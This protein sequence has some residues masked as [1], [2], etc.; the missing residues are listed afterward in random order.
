MQINNYV[1]AKCIQ[2]VNYI[3]CRLCGEFP[4]PK[5]QI[6][7]TQIPKNLQGNNKLIHFIKTDPRNQNDKFFC[8]IYDNKF[9]H[10]RAGGNWEKKI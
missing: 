9:L 6:T 10:Y 7:E 8:E 2:T 1:A 4:I 3:Q 5:K